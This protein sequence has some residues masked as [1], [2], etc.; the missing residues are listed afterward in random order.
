MNTID[1]RRQLK[2]RRDK[3]LGRAVKVRDDV[4]HKPGLD[5]DFSEQAVQRENDD[6]LANLD[7]AIR[8]ELTQIERAIRRIDQA[9]YEVC[10]MC[11]RR[12]SE[13]R[14]EA[15]PYATRCITCEGHATAKSAE[16][17]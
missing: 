11:H 17:T 10:E 4:R 15:L 7:N 3:L 1:I 9:N 8:A 2:A 16:P 13:D 6:V 12:I 14:L 5:P